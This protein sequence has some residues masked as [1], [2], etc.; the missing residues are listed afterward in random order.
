M[1]G[2]QRIHVRC[3]N[4]QRVIRRY[5]QLFTDHGWR[6]GGYVVPP[7]SSGRLWITFYRPRL[8]SEVHDAH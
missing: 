7:P 6:Y 4:R 8:Q 2:W 5:I 3:D 1:N